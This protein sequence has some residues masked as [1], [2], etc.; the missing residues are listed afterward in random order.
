VK[1]ALVTEVACN[2]NPADI[3]TLEDLRRWNSSTNSS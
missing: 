2:G 3:D 1:P